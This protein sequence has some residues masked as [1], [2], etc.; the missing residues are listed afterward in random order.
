MTVPGSVFPWVVLWRHRGLLLQFT[1]RA[2]NVRHRG[3]ML[4]FVWAVLNPLLMLGL[5][6][7]IFGVVFSG[8]FDVLPDETPLDYAFTIFLGLIFFHLIAETLA[9]SPSLVA[10]NPNFV[11]KVVFPLEILPASAVGASLF[12]FGI[13]LVLFF[14]GALVLGHQFS[15]TA[16]WLPVIILPIVLLALGLAW[17][18]SAL[19]VFLRDLQQLV[20]FV[21][22]VLLYASCVFFPTAK[23][24]AE[25][26]AIL[27]FNP[28]LQTVDLAR[29]TVLWGHDPALLRLAYTYAAG[30]LVFGGGYLIFRVTRPAFADVV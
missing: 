24:P 23:V 29:E 12:H 2:I 5:Y 10:T 16:L 3:S 6:T 21:N 14:L 17:A 22:L 27:R 25:V 15:A 1:E 18:L 7:F 4:G 30:A 19:G 8:R 11:K 20:G 28:L 9:A 26:W 13:S